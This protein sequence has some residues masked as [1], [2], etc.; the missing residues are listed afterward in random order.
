MIADNTN[1]LAPI[2][3]FVYNRPW[4]TRQTVEALQKNELAS[5]SV[6]YV[7]ADGPKLDATEE[8]INEI[9]QTRKYIHSVQGFKEIH[10]EESEKNKGL[11]DSIVEGVTKILD[12]YG[13]VIVLEDDIVT[14]SGFLK[15]MNSALTLYENE[16]KVMHVAG[17]MYPLKRNT[18]PETFFYPAASCW[19]WA[20]WKRAWDHYNPDARDLYMKIKE[21]RLLK[22][23]NINSIHGFEE[24]LRANMEGTMYTWFIKWN[25]SVILSHGYSLYPNCSLVQNVG[26]D[27]SGEHCGPTNRFNWLKLADN[28]EVKK[29]RV[30]FSKKA[31]RL[32][33][34]FGDEERT[35]FVKLLKRRCKKLIKKI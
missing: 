18:L 16:E 27:G 26:F 5:E 17:Y 4:H 10:V 2:I 29:Q 9:V 19:G 28:I 6:L 12:V 32:L 21:G 23:L 35:S 14:S 15:F 24:Q 33:R 30:R 7:F 1:N 34:Q 20:T 25:A 13:K 11:A 3:L 22:I 8:Q 31:I